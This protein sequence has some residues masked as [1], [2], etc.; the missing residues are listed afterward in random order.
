MPPFV[1]VLHSEVPNDGKQLAFPLKVE[2][3]FELF[4]QRW[5][6]S[7]LAL[8]YHWTHFPKRVRLACEEYSTVLLNTV[9]LVCKERTMNNSHNFYSSRYIYINWTVRIG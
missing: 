7:V 1:V 5:E 4:S 3:G 2:L 9:I 6:V 8:P